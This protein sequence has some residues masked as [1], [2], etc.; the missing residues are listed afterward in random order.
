M[1]SKRFLVVS[2]HDLHPGSLPQVREQVEVLGSLGV[3]SF[4]ILAVPFFH[5]EKELAR[6]EKTLAW[7][8]ERARAGDDIVLHGF[9]HDRHDRQGG[10]YFHTKVYTAG[11]A[12]FLD[13]PDS[14]VR[15]RISQAL[16]LWKERG[17]A[18]DGFIAPGWLMP[19]VQDRI[20]RGMGFQYTTRL[21]GFTR[22]K[23]SRFTASQSLCYS[24]R[25][26]WRRIA[27]LGWNAWLGWRVRGCEL[28]R[29]SLHPND[30]C[31][32][33]IRRQICRWV[34]LTLA[35]GRE[36]ITYAKYAAL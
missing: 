16:V 34:E 18:T 21:R 25:A 11:E 5:Q 2:L 30:F 10:S 36:P 17:W 35:E 31:H 9:F 24:T 32:P 8:D 1:K 3:K 22:L 26:N 7:L 29:L 14:Q 12:E 13:L 6:D 28:A 15:E 20:L 19:E 23:T 33:R 27:S 4:S